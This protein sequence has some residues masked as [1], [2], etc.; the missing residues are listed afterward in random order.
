MMGRS[1]ATPDR[2]WPGISNH[3]HQSPFQ[4]RSCNWSRYQFSVKPPPEKVTGALTPL[5][6]LLLSRQQRT[7]FPW[8]PTPPAPCMPTWLQ[9]RESIFAPCCHNQI[10]FQL[11]QGYSSTTPCFHATS[12]PARSRAL[13]PAPVKLFFSRISSST[14][15]YNSWKNKVLMV[16]Q[17]NSWCLHSLLYP[18]LLAVQVFTWRLMHF[19]PCKVRAV[20]E[21]MI[22]VGL[23][24]QDFLIQMVEETRSKPNISSQQAETHSFCI[25]SS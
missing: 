7:A 15:V 16:V 10:L 5:L 13:L 18:N 8:S 23:H 25:N 17:D 1:W 2:C 24:L 22:S 3:W 19:L 9:G 6:P 21:I 14:S 4:P 12:C 20:N 11:P